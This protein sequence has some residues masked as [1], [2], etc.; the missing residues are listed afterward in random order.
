MIEA[1][2]IITI[3]K[4]D[5]SNVRLF[6]FTYEGV[7]H[8]LTERQ[9]KEFENRYGLEIKLNKSKQLTYDLEPN[10]QN[11]ESI[12]EFFDANSNNA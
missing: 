8:V 12:S 7:E 6:S 4:E 10:Y 1:E 11:I 5:S 9:I 3:R 2:L